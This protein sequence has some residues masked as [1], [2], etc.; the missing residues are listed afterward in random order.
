MDRA[1]ADV[2]AFM[3]GDAENARRSDAVAASPS[4]KEDLI[5]S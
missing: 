3:R 2:L 5:T 1:E 4:Y